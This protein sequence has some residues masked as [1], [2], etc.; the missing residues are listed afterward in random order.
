MAG[1]DIGND[2]QPLC[3][4]PLSTEL[5]IQRICILEVFN[6]HG[7]NLRPDYG[8][9]RAVPEV[10]EIVS[11]FHSVFITSEQ[12]S[13]YRHLTRINVG[14][15]GQLQL[16]RGAGSNFSGINRGPKSE[17]KLLSRH[18]GR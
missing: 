18:H 17:Q 13:G 3:S 6:F 5:D 10:F 1:I 14:K 11:N 16:E 15:T 4:N 12:P 7:L 8:T 2:P 9:I